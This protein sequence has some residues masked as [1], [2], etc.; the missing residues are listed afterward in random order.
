MVRLHYNGIGTQG[1][2][3]KNSSVNKLISAVEKDGFF[4]HVDWR[5][6]RYCVT[7]DY[8]RKVIPN[9]RVEN[10][11][12]NHHNLRFAPEWGVMKGAV[13]SPALVTHN[14]AQSSRKQEDEIVAGHQGTA[15]VLE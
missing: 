14:E 11:L 9:S 7:P 13:S 4:G 10:V 1:Y 15:A 8:V 2:F 6:M 5:L 3:V 12:H